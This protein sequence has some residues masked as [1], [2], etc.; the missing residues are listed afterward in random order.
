MPYARSDVE[1][2]TIPQSASFPTRCQPPI[3]LPTCRPGCSMSQTKEQTLVS[4]VTQQKF[5]QTP[6]FVTLSFLCTQHEAGLKA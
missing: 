5:P 4:I 6:A 1:D 3:Q 2:I